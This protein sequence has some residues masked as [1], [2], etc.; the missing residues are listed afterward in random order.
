MA[1]VLD[2][3]ELVNRAKYAFRGTDRA[4]YNYQLRMSEDKFGKKEFFSARNDNKTSVTLDPL[5]AWVYASM[6]HEKASS[7]KNSPLQQELYDF[8]P[9]IL[10]INLQSYKDKI[11][12][13][14]EG[15]GPVAGLEYKINGPISSNDIQILQENHINNLESYLT[16]LIKGVCPGQPRGNSKEDYLIFLKDFLKKFVNQSAL[17]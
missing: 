15:G 10:L 12:D 2:P 6:A 14:L 1:I 13:G 11:R 17:Q 5:Y 4:F 9:I 8:G 3:M 7:I 16:E